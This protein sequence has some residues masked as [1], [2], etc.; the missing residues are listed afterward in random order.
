MR[1]H[2]FV[3]SNTNVLLFSC[4]LHVNKTALD[5]T[6][7]VIDKIRFSACRYEFRWAV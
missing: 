7:I 6:L 1:P 2:F 5:R 3:Y 4:D